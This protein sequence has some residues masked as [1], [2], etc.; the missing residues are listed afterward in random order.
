LGPAE[1]DHN[2]KTFT[3]ARAWYVAVDPSVG[4]TEKFETWSAT[5]ADTW[6]VKDLSGYGV[7]ANAVCEIVVYNKDTKYAYYSGVRAVDSLLERMF[8]LQNVE[9][10][11]WDMVTMFVQANGS[12]VIEYYSNDTTDVW[13]ILVGYWDLG[14]YVEKMEL[15]NA[16]SDVTWADKDLSGYG[17]SA[18]QICEIVMVNKNALGPKEAGVRTNGSALVRNVS[19][20]KAEKLDSVDAATMLVK[21][22]ANSKIEAYAETDTDIDFYL[23]GYWTT[24]PGAYTETFVDIGK[25]TADHEWKEKNL[26]VYGVPANAVAEII[27][28]DAENAIENEQGVRKVGSALA[29]KF[30]VQEAEDG[31]RDMV[32]VHVAANASSWIEFYH[33]DISD[34]HNFTLVGYWSNTTKPNV[35]FQNQTVSI[36]LLMGWR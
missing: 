31:G 11:G 4:Y 34:A 25:P 35:L 7:P 33:E 12:S 1:I 15:F 26:S 6:E 3:E 27:L 30:D 10:G 28:A 23:V 17:V 16:G 36:T 8:P 32:S 5:T 20:R 18:N 13:F 21:A 14:T 2:E 19:I 29:R 22:D 24:S 9:H